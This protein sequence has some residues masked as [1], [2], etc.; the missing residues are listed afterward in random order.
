MYYYLQTRGKLEHDNTNQKKICDTYQVFV[1]K[2]EAEATFMS[3]R[4]PIVIF[5]TTT[6][7]TGFRVAMQKC[8]FVCTI[9][10]FYIRTLFQV[11]CRRVVDVDGDFATSCVTWC[12]L[13]IIAFLF[14]FR[15]LPERAAM[16]GYQSN[17]AKV[18]VNQS[19]VRIYKR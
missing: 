10:F 5:F 17:E 18:V 3:T 1:G 6:I 14:D 8:P 19:S 7:I 15:G 13:D 12:A 9:Y 11:K 4:F 2:V 16:Q